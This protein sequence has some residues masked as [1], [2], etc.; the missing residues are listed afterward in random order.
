MGLVSQLHDMALRLGEEAR[1]Q[2][3]GDWR[4]GMDAPM[5]AT[6]TIGAAVVSTR[7]M[8]AMT[9]L[10]TAQAVVAREVRDPGPARWQAGAQPAALA[11][12]LGELAAAVD[13]LYGRIVA[14]DAEIR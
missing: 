10:L 14:A 4:Q 11:G 5:R 7:L 12:R 1:R 13:R 9:W 6:A 2:F 8:E 3:A